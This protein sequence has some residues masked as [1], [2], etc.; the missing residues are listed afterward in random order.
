MLRGLLPSGGAA[1]FLPPRE[2]G[3]EESCALIASE[4]LASAYQPA[5]E[6]EEFLP[7]HTA[8]RAAHYAEGAV[9]GSL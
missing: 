3:K 5:G 6:G 7:S 8:T 1:R 2:E 9:L 4:N